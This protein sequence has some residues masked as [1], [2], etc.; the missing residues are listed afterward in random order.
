MTYGVIDD[1]GIWIV[2]E[3]TAFHSLNAAQREANRRN[4]EEGCA[5]SDGTLKAEFSQSD[6]KLWQRVHLTRRE[7]TCPKPKA[8]KAGAY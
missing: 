3:G 1:A 2:G 8:V 6:E 5:H 4:F 7:C